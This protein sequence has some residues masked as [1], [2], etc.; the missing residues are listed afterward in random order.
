MEEVANIEQPIEE[1]TEKTPLPEESSEMTSQAEAELLAKSPEAK[2]ELEE[3]EV[4][5]HKAVKRKTRQQN[6]FADGNLIPE[7]GDDEEIN[8]SKS[9]GPPPLEPISQILDQDNQKM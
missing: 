9:P 7:E 8:H 6:K 5:V 2:K 3:P 1:N 4:Q